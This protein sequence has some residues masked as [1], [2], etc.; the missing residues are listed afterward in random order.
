VLP[1][2]IATWAAGVD[3]ERSVVAYCT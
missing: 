1:D 3:R 2:H